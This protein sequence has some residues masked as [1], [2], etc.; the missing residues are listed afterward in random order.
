MI[1]GRRGYA[2]STFALV[3]LAMLA[4]ASPPLLAQVTT[5]QIV[6][7]V[8]D[9]D[10]NPIE[11]AQ[12]TITH[13]PTATSAVVTTRADGYF[14]LANARV[15]G[16]YT[17]AVAK[18]GYDPT[19]AEG[20]STQVGRPTSVSL[21]MRLA[22]TEVVVAGAREQQV[23]LGA[24]TSFSLQDIEGMPSIGRDIKDIARID[25]KI[26]IDAANVDAMEIAGTNNK[27]NSITVDGI[28]ESDDFGLNN[29]G[30]PSNRAPVT[31]DAIEAFTVEVAPFDVQY[32]GFQ[33]GTVNI[34]TKSGSNDFHGSAW[35]VKNQD[36]W[37]G[38]RSKERTVNLNFDEFSYGATLGGP[39]LRD[40]LFFFLSYEKV[41]RETPV[42]EGP[43]G[44]G[45]PVSINQVSQADFNQILAI[46][47]SVYGYDPGELVRSNTEED[48]RILAKLDWQITDD[49][50]LSLAYQR[51]EGLTIVQPNANAA[52][53][54]LG[55][56]SN[57][58]ERPIDLENL[59]L[60]LFSTWTPWLSTEFKAGRKEVTAPQTPVFGANFAEF[61]IRT[62][63]PAGAGIV[64]VGPDEFRHANVLTNDL[65]TFKL[66]ADMLFGDHTVTVGTELEQLDVFNQ[67]VPRSLGQYIFNSI[68]DYQNRTAASF[69]YSNAVTNNAA[70]GA[71]AF[72]TD[73]LSFYL[74]DSWRILPELT[75]QGGLRYERYSSGD[76]PRA[77][78]NFASRYGF[79][80]TETYDGRDLLLPR[81]G[82]DWEITADTKIR[83]GV[84]LFGGGSPTVW[85]SNSFA[86]DGVAIV[87]QNCPANSMSPTVCSAPAGAPIPSAQIL[88]NVNGSAIPAAILAAQGTLAGDGPVNAIDPDYEIA[89][90]WRYN[91][92]LEHFFDLGSLGNNYRVSADLIYTAVKDQILYR[93]LRLQRTG[94]APDGRPIYAQ[95]GPS[96][97]GSAQ[98]LL[99][100]NTD[101]GRGIVWTLDLT[102][103]WDTR[104]GRFDAYLGYG[105]QDIKDV[106]PGTSSQASSNWDNVA[107][108]DPNDPE[109]ATSNYQITHR[110]PLQLTWRKAFFGDYKT[111]VGLFVERRSG[112]PFSYTFGSATS[113]FGDPR[114]NARQ[115]QLFYVPLNAG[116]VDYAGG[117]TAQAL[118]DFI[119]ASGLDKYRGQIAPRN[120]FNSPWVTAADL[121]LSQEIPAF[122]DSAR[123]VV[124]LDIRN[125]A[126][127]I[128]KDWGR[129]ASVQF[130]YVAP[131]LNATINPAT[132]RYTYS[133]LP[134]RTAPAPAN[135]VMS[136]AQSSVWQM[137][138]GVRFE[139]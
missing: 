130:P 78:A 51:N 28:R 34:V 52:T 65:N 121:R 18:D 105:H 136:P 56:R 54:R 133:P 8:D 122:F 29:N 126:N 139:F 106:N 127:L 118:D 16:P 41:E 30:Y 2:R 63:T 138:L 92:G 93:D 94:T 97:R 131:V 9:T 5:G 31:L 119:V 23:A 120:A 36:S 79:S 125:V 132:G 88:T 89:S 114:Q 100:T 112:R 103:S 70:D 46:T 68:A 49:H 35:Y 137:Q 32:S 64:H 61:Q 24:G 53:G 27:Y 58:Y 44:A 83:G 107:T 123:A 87:A 39:I 98:D 10:G 38:D 47:Q 37:A 72:G 81:L 1:T 40:R 6:G 12:V 48:E 128:N 82:F 17:I 7:Q 76:R 134:G 86:N 84:G 77:N 59:S 101:E 71:A 115:R 11:G 26:W 85:L 95:R 113:A 62:T 25:P 108:S 14:S 104:Y 69:S 50:R 4:L 135:F 80:N 60:Q 20:I 75:V 21:Q 99:L 102:G 91:L 57:W 19:R 96:S 3:C 45:F 117:L 109:L 73:T 67:F 124:T 15:G 66:K 43:G 90:S 129:L 111:H 74:Q 22:L 13:V 42:N 116:D 55:T 110:F 33:G